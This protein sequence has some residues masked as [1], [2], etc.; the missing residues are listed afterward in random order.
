[1]TKTYYLFRI[2]PVFGCCLMF[3]FFYY[4]APAQNHLVSGQ[5]TDGQEPISGASIIIKHTIKGTVS[6]FDGHY[7][8]DAQPIDTLQISY[9]GYKTQELVVGNQRTIDVVLQED[10]TALGEVVINA[11]YYNTTEKAK[12]GSIAR[13]TA[14]EIETQPV[15]NPLAAMQGR[16][17]GVDIVQTSGV[18]GSG[19]D[20]RIRGQNSI[21]GGNAPLYIVDGVPFDGQTLGSS[22]SS[23]T[24]IPLGNISP[25]NAINPA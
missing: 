25:L 5:I 4:V 11:G 20:V 9:L 6:D 21:M 7:E 3:F 2:R 1:M 16:M 23:V 18:P 8:L 14:K 22:N 24:V 12:T 10:A 19:F 17:T 13:I 15:S